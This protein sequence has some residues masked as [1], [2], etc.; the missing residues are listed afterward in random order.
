MAFLATMFKAI[1]KEIERKAATWALGAV[2]DWQ[3]TYLAQYTPQKY[4]DE[5]AGMGEG[6]ASVGVKDLDKIAAR[7]VTLANLPGDIQHLL[8]V[9]EDEMVPHHAAR[10]DAAGDDAVAERLLLVH[11]EV[12]APMGDEAV[13]LAEGARIEQQV[14]AL[15]R[16]QAAGRVLPCDAGFSATR[17]GGVVHLVQSFELLAAVHGASASPLT[18]VGGAGPRYA[19]LLK[20]PFRGSP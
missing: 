9:I 2:A 4:L 17:E 13:Q 14:D 6:G 1:P 5:I 7:M 10:A 18:V 20:F 19:S 12:G 8:W 11:A 16:R 3:W 15:P